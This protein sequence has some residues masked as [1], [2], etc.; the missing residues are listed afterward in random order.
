MERLQTKTSP[1][2][3]RTARP[4]GKA[5]RRRTQREQRMPAGRAA[6]MRASAGMGLEDTEPTEWL[7]GD[8]LLGKP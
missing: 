7:F 6:A 8:S 4:T 1:T 5:G 3:K 2:A